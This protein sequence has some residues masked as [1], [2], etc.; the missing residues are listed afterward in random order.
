M[1]FVIV[2]AGAVGA[3]V[4]TLLANAGHRVHF[5]VRPSQRERLRTLSIERSGGAQL[6]IESPSL[7][8]QGDAVPPSDWVLVCVRGEQLTLALSE[9]VQFMGPERRVAIAAVSLERV[10]ARARAAGVTGPVFALHAAFGSHAEPGTPNHFKWFPFKPPT[11]VT[12]DEQR[13]L[14][15]QAKLLAATLKE[16]GLPASSL[17]GM[18]A[19]MRFMAGVLSALSLSW[20]LCGWQLQGLA[21]N[22]QLR[23]ETAR[24]M[25]DA[26][27]LLVAP[28]SWP[29]LLPV[30]FYAAALRTGAWLM[31]PEGREVWLYHG[32]KIREQTDA[33]VREI[34][35]QH[36]EGTRPPAALSRLFERWQRAA[37]SA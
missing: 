30:W 24:A 25:Q 16:A 32:P 19:Y 22:A 29:L 13:A 14:L 1:D 36:A 12:P 35:A 20:D 5:W 21:A 23:R 11:T 3:V 10:G 31:T 9:V 28:G 6:S 2:G 27:R 8:S 34:L 37:R 17:L 15:P 4:G 18:N 7:L 33:F 26:A